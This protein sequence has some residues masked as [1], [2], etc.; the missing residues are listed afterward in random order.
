MSRVRVPSPTPFFLPSFLPRK[1]DVPE[2]AKVILRGKHLFPGYGALQAAT[3][4]AGHRPEI[5]WRETQLFP[6]NYRRNKKR[7]KRKR[8]MP[9]I[10]PESAA[11]RKTVSPRK[12]SSG[13]PVGK[14]QCRH[15][16]DRL[17]CP[18]FPRFRDF[19]VRTAYAGER[20][21]SPSRD[22]YT[23]PPCANQTEKHARPQEKTPPH[24][25]SSR[26]SRLQFRQR[27]QIFSRVCS[28]E[29]VRPLLRL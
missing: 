11:F 29:S 6:G 14:Y 17:S 22:Y 27:C 23:M 19:R 10:P 21:R 3:R 8:S 25:L 9:C 18:D 24:A 28:T 13:P 4:S 16:A 2:N 7:H 1:E 20:N 12:R 15:H 5:N 26:C